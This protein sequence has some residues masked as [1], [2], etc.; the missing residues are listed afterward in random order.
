MYQFHFIDAKAHCLNDIP[1]AKQGT[2]GDACCT[3]KDHPGRHCEMRG[4]ATG[5]KQH[6][7]HTHTFL[8]I[9][10]AVAECQP[11]YRQ[12]LRKNKQWPRLYGKPAEQPKEQFDDK[13]TYYKPC[14][15]REEHTRYHFHKPRKL[16]MPQLCESPIDVLRAQCMQASTYQPA[17][18]RCRRRGWQPKLPRNEIIPYC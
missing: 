14:K 15:W 9:I 5:K 13:D 4:N 1:P 12:V 17:G 6:R 11:G 7:Y 10:G 18:K 3:K 2:R 16:K 8:R